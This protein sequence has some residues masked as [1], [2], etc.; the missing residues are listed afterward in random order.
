[1]IFFAYFNALGL[2]KKHLL[3]F[4]FKDGHVIALAR[5]PNGH[6]IAHAAP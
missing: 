1:M 6:V 3:F 2:E 4:N 5:A